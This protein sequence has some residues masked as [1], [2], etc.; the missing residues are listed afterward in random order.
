MYVVLGRVCDIGIHDDRKIRG[1][2]HK[3]NKTQ[4]KPN[5]LFPMILIINSFLNL[6]CF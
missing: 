3:E 1:E 4:R 6:Q 2:N 5:I